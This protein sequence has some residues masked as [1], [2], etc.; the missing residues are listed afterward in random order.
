VPSDPFASPP[1]PGPL[2]YFRLH[3]KT[4][5]RYRY[6][7]QDLAELAGMA[8]GREEVYVMFNNMSMWEMLKPFPNI[9]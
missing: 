5:Y 6:R 8:Q 4:G 9:S 7:E 1:Y 2:A 3:G